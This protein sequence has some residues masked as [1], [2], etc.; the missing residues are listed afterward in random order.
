MS[1]GYL[2]QMLISTTGIEAFVYVIYRLSLHLL[3]VY[4]IRDVFW[5]GK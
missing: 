5:G 3:S 2:I 1:H 4:Q